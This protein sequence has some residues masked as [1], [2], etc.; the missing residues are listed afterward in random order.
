MLR[1][2]LHGQG[3]TALGMVADGEVGVLAA[4]LAERIV[5]ES[6]AD[7]ALTQ[8]TVDRFLSELDQQPSRQAPDYVPDNLTT[9]GQ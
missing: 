9:Q 7:T 2:P 4:Q 5:G 8:R 6:L 3:G 1:Q